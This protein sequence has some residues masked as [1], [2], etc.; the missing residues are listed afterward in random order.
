MNYT[1]N[2]LWCVYILSRVRIRMVRVFATNRRSAQFCYDCGCDNDG[3]TPCYC[4]RHAPT[5]D[6]DGIFGL[7]S[8]LQNQDSSWKFKHFF[9]LLLQ[10]ERPEYEMLFGDFEVNIAL[11]KAINGDIS[12]NNLVELLNSKIAWSADWPRF[13]HLEEPKF[14]DF[15]TSCNMKMSKCRR[16]YE[17]MEDGTFVRYC[18]WCDPY[19]GG[20]DNDI[21]FEDHDISTHQCNGCGRENHFDR[22]EIHQFLLRNC[23]HQATVERLCNDCFSSEREDR[24]HVEWSKVE[25]TGNRSTWERWEHYP[26]RVTERVKDDQRRKDWNREPHSWGTKS[27]VQL[28]WN[29]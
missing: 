7:L 18:S 26:D 11:S 15:C 25:T 2:P 1:I 20:R 27:P 16:G 10:L 23:E 3:T 22:I 12:F 17:G 6:I 8:N 14:D 9:D 28:Y 19:I 24:M 4:A 13:N 29:W 5:G 21:D